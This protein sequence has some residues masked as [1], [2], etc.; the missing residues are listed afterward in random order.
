MIHREIFM[1]GRRAGALLLAIVLGAVGIA[2]HAQTAAD[3]AGNAA[4]APLRTAQNDIALPPPEMMEMQPTTEAVPAPPSTAAL[5]AVRIALLLPLRSAAFG[6]AAQAVQAGFTAAYVRQQD[7]IVI[8]VVATDGTVQDTLAGY[9]SAAATNDIVVGPL[10]RSEVGAVARSGAVRVPTIALGQPEVPGV[11]D[12]SVPPNML[13]IGLSIEDEARQVARLASADKTIGKA[14]VVS[15]GTTWQRRAAQAFV[16]QW[17]AL[18]LVAD[19][20][21]LKV[22]AGYVSP[23][24]LLEVKRRLQAA[25]PQ[26]MFVALD[27]ALTGQ[28]RLAVGTE[29]PMVGTS[30]LNPLAFEDWQLSEGVPDMDGARLIDMPWELQADHAAVMSYPRMTVA[31]DQRRN[32]D[33]DRLY[34]LGIDAY[35]IAH[36][37]AGN[38]RDFELDGVTGRLRIHFSSV[39][40]RFEREQQTALYQEGKVAP[41]NG[42]W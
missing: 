15:T 17:R 13:V 10:A 3:V 19:T 24:S 31:P 1:M 33:L 26:C 20:V 7:G 18:G 42:L 22:E 8:E 12:A 36:E 34:A 29:V 35:R 28:L 5:R 4:T 41:S 37:L 11:P 21:E 16:A 9:A 23:D 40:T 27:A 2:A 39:G 14:L 6:A 30:Q 32:V 25:P 38:N